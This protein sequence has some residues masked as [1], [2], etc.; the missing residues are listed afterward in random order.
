MLIQRTHLFKLLFALLTVSVFVSVSAQDFNDG[1]WDERFGSPG[2]TCCVGF[3]FDV[4][5][6]ETGP[7]GIYAGGTFQQLGEQYGTRGIARWDGHRW[8]S[9][10]GRTVYRR[11]IL[12]GG[13]HPGL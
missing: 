2:V 1:L 12:R 6:A 10:D 9:L 8:H 4:I 13:R 7:D 5:T 3:S 11:G